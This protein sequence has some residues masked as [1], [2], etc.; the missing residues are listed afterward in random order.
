MLPKILYVYEEKDGDEKYFIAN[1]NIY[2][3]IEVGNKKLVGTY[4]LTE[5]NSIE[6]VAKITQLARCTQ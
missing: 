4:K 2:D 3:C 6:A 5:K 1:K